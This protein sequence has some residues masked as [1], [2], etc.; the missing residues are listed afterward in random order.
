M[1]AAKHFEIVPHPADGQLLCKIHTIIPVELRHGRKIRESGVLSWV[2]SL[3]FKDGISR[4]EVKMQ[5]SVYCL[6]F[7]SK[8]VL[9][10]V[11]GT[12]Y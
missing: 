4:F 5:S 3:K 7:V 12:K 6:P 1:V 2:L 9:N 8:E 10:S 11:L